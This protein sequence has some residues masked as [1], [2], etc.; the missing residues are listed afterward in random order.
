MQCFLFKLP[1]CKDEAISVWG[2]VSASI[3]ALESSKP[4]FEWQR[5]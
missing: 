2:V 1:P 5:V 3:D 4:G